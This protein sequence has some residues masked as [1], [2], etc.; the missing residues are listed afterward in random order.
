MRGLVT[1]ARVPKVMEMA[2]RTPAK[3]G[4]MSRWLICQPE[5]A[6]PET[7]RARVRMV[8]EAPSEVTFARAQNNT[9]WTPKPACV[10]M[11]EVGETYSFN[12]V[13]ETHIPT[14]VRSLR[15]KVVVV[16]AMRR[17]AMEPLKMETSDMVEKG[18]A[19]KIPF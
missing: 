8:I 12:D 7:A 13:D 17:S 15:T 1:P 4:A 3:E 6:R 2:T 11:R 14:H 9:P 18:R 19:E 16:W 10:V 5:I